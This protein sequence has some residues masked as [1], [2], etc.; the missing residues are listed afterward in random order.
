MMEFVFWQSMITPHQAGLVRALADRSDCSVTYVAAETVEA[1]RAAMGWQE[2]SLGPATLKL[3]ETPADI[4]AAAASFGERAIH[5]CQGFRGNGVI[6]HALPALAERGARIGVMM[7]A[8][9]R[10]GPTGWLKKPLY[11]RRVQ[12]YRDKV[13]FCLAIG[14]DGGEFVAECGFPSDRI[15]PFSYFLNP[16]DQPENLAKQSKTR[17]LLYVGKLIELKRVDLLIEAF[18]VLNL[19]DVSLSVVGA[20]P[21]EQKLRAFAGKQPNAGAIEWL[22]TLDNG[23]VQRLIADSDCLVLPS[24]YDGWGA[25]VTEALLAG[26]PAVCS[27]AC[28]A[29]VAVDCAPAGSVFTSG[30]AS[31]LAAKLRAQL[32]LPPVSTGQR[33]ML[34]DWA[35]LALSD[36]AGAQYLEAIIASIAQNAPSPPAPWTSVHALEKPQEIKTFVTR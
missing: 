22:G 16:L 7:E 30:N 27:S 23:S 2:P 1:S 24:E 12:R 35:S 6:E 17:R 9:D 29:A 4:A 10:R 18:G 20:G 3:A 5:I 26:T 11:Q 28:G 31:V 13:E 14:A 19:P 32:T 8:V 25:V 21:L 36:Q 34:R 33:S 15:Y